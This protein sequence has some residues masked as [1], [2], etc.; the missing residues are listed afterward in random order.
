MTCCD[1]CADADLYI[2]YVIVCRKMCVFTGMYIFVCVCKWAHALTCWNVGAQCVCSRLCLCV[3][4]CACVFC[5]YRKKSG[6]VTVVMV[7]VLCPTWARHSTL[8]ILWS[9]T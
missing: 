8:Q 4:V 2:E 9:Y 7:A 3:C 6:V 1:V 5:K